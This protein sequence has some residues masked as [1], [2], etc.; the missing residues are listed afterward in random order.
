MVRILGYSWNGVEL[1]LDKRT[2]KTNGKRL[3]DG[4]Y[5]F[6]TADPNIHINIRSLAKQVENRL[7]L[8]L[9]VAI[10]P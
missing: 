6:R 8:W 7:Q 3:N 10:L 1:P 9:S 4:C 5:L 2:F